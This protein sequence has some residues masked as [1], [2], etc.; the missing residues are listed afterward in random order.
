[1]AAIVARPGIASR[2]LLLLAD[3]SGGDGD[4]Q[5]GCLTRSALQGRIA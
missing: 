4:F 2:L 5:G 1:M 3:A